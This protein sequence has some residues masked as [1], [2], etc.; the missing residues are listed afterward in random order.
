M[1]TAS[2][3]L[4]TALL[5]R[6]QL[7][8]LTGSGLLVPPI[9]GRAVKAA[10]F[11]SNKWG[12]VEELD[13]ALTVVR[14]SLGRA[15]E[16]A[17]LQRDDADLSRLALADLGN[18][19]GREL[20]PVAVRV[21][22]WGGALPQPAVGHVDAIGRALAAVAAVPGLALAGA[23]VGGV[24]IPACIATATRAADAVGNALPAEAATG[25]RALAQDLGTQ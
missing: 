3:A 13:P 16:E 7:E 23:A 4:V 21:A 1:S 2:I 22:R 11:S 10:T 8:G 18:L 15:G 17:V 14:A 20:R 9:E 5:P 6:A 24:G 19:L 12:W 25:H